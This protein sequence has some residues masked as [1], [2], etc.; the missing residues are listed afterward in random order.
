MMNHGLEITTSN[1]IKLVETKNV[2]E[3][4]T[5]LSENSIHE[6]KEVPQ[7]IIKFSKYS[8][9][10]SAPLTQIVEVSGNE[11]QSRY[12]IEAT[13]AMSS[14]NAVVWDEKLIIDINGVDM[15]NVPE[16]IRTDI[17]LYTEAIRTSQYNEEE[18]TGRFVFDLREKTIPREVSVNKERTMLEITFN[19]VGLSEIEIGQDREGDYIELAGDY[20]Q[21]MII[22][23]ES[24]NGL[25]FDFPNSVNL[26]GNKRFMMLKGQF[27]EWVKLAQKD[28]ST[29]RL[30]IGTAEHIDYSIE[31]DEKENRTR[32]RLKALTF[33]Q[34]NYDKSKNNAIILPKESG[35]ELS[36][37]YFNKAATIKY[38]K[39]ISDISKM[40]KIH[41]HDEMY[42]TIEMLVENNRSLVRLQGKHIYEYRI[43]EDEDFYYIYGTRPRDI[44]EYIVVLDP[45]HGGKQPGAVYYGV[46]EKDLNSKLM[47]YIYPHTEKNSNIKYYFT[48]LSDKTVSLSQRT[49]MAND[50][51]ADLFVAMHNN[52]MDL[53]SNPAGSRVRGLEF[54]TTTG[55]EK[56]E[57]EVA[58]GKIFLEKLRE[59]MPSYPIRAIKNNNKLYVL[60]NTDMPSVIIEYGYMTN[61]E[62]MALLQQD[63]ILQEL[64]EVTEAAINEYI[65]NK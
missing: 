54:Y 27:L 25:I 64:A 34:L 31:Y 62:D 48:R 40:E 21:A 57:T 59:A 28:E 1:L 37:D 45:G 16:T 18:M 9:E 35:I 44:Y 22:R 42:D 43:E 30:S 4:P 7:D 29:V 32:L 47:E 53:K 6:K 19:E 39:I 65:L 46:D 5:E 51:E 60:R 17:S 10:N 55:W 38:E 49:T 20:R 61:L 2:P 63:N 13:G 41:V 23:T 36:Y 58:L 3:L 26:L 8:D 15:E 52:A 50:L 12:Y 33:H 11:D 56:S 14:V 24:P